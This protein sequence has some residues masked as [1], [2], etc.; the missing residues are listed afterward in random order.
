M[1]DIDIDQQ[2]TWEPAACDANNFII[3]LEGGFDLFLEGAPIRALDFVPVKLIL[4]KGDGFI[5]QWMRPKVEREHSPRLI[6]KVHRQ[7][8]E[9]ANLRIDTRAYYRDLA[10]LP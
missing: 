3:C 1:S 10:M 9:R 4:L 5:I 6:I 2:G 8:I 7:N